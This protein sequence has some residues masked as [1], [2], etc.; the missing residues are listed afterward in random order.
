M[1][2]VEIFSPD[3]R[4]NY[5][6]SAGAAVGRVDS[7][8]PN[9]GWPDLQARSPAFAAGTVRTIGKSL[10]EPHDNEMV[11]AIRQVEQ[12][13]AHALLRLARQLGRKTEE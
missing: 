2:N 7:S 10:E 5:P 11:P 13:I 8:W 6:A 3:G 12:R 1:K 4:T 9:S